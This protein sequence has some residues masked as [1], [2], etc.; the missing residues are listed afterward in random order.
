MIRN[1]NVS[2]KERKV[3]LVFWELPRVLALFTRKR[4]DLSNVQSEKEQERLRSQI[5]SALIGATIEVH[6]RFRFAAMNSRERGSNNENDD[7][8]AGGGD[9]D[10]DADEDKVKSKSRLMD[11]I[12]LGKDLSEMA[13]KLPNLMSNQNFLVDKLTGGLNT[14]NA[15]FFLYATRSAA[16]KWKTRKKMID[17]SSPGKCFFKSSVILR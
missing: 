4:A 3:D 6:H 9:G 15:L 2:M 12:D 10:A 1:Y 7:D 16:S 14:G 8:D 5:R 13:S 17:K 11:E